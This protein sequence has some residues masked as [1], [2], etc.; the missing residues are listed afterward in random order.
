MIIL[1]VLLLSLLHSTGCT[2]Y[3]VTPDDHYY[4]NTTCHHCHCLQYYMLNTTKYFTSNTQILFLPGLHHLHTDLI[5]QS[6]HNISLIGSTTN[7]TASDTIIQ[8]NSSIGIVLTNVTNLVI[9]HITINNCTKQYSSTLKNDLLLEHSYNVQLAHVALFG[10]LQPSRNRYALRAVNVLGSSVFTDL[11]C[12]GI[13]VKYNETIVQGKHHKLLIEDYHIVPD[14]D[15]HGNTIIMVLMYQELYKVEFEVYNSKFSILDEKT[16]F[17]SQLT[18]N[19]FGNLIHINY[20]FITQ[21]TYSKVFYFKVSS[22][23]SCTAAHH[24]VKFTNSKFYDSNV[25]GL[26]HFYMRMVVLI[27]IESIIT[28]VEIKNCIFKNGRYEHLIHLYANCYG[29]NFTKIS[30]ISISNTTFS[31]MNSLNSLIDISN[32]LLLLEGPVVFTQINIVLHNAI[33]SLCQEDGNVIFHNYIEFSESN[34]DE[35]AFIAFEMCQ[36][37]QSRNQDRYIVLQENTLVNIT[38]NNYTPPLHKIR[39]SF[40]PPCYFQFISERDNLDI[41]FAIGSPL[42]Y[43]IVLNNDRSAD[44]FQHVMI[45]CYWLSGTAFTTTK[46]YDVYRKF[47]K[48]DHPL[49]THERVICSC[50][51]NSYPDCHTHVLATIYPGQTLTQQLALNQHQLRIFNSPSLIKIETEQSIVPETACNLV[52]INEVNQLL[53]NH[54]TPTQYTIIHSDFS[55]YTYWCELFIAIRNPAF[56]EK[57][58]YNIFLINFLSCPPGFAQLNGTCTCD[59]LLNSKQLSITTCDINYQAIL[60]PANAWLS[61]I[62]TNNS[63]QYRVSP[64]CPLRY[65]LPH[66]TQLNFSTLNSQCQ[67]NRSGQLCGQCQQGLSTVFGSSQCQDCS[68]S[69][70]YLFLIIPFAIAG[71]VLVLLLFTLNLTVTDGDINGFVLYVNIISINSHVFFPVNNSI[72]PSYIFISI[73]NLDLGIQTCFYNGMDDYAKMWLQLVF[74]AYLI[75]IATSLIIASRHSTRIQRVTACRALPIL[76]TLFLLSYT[77]VLHT[78]SSV[79]FYYSTIVHLPSKHTRL[80]WAV[81]ANI[82]LFGFKHTILFVVCLILFIILLLFNAILIFTKVLSRFK[83]I[84]RFKPLID[85]FQGPHK[86][87]YYYWTGVQLVMRAVFFGLSALDRNVNLSI[88]V[89]LLAITIAVHADFIPFKEKAKHYNETIFLLNLLILYTFSFGYHSVGVDI[90]IMIAAVQLV[91]IIIYHVITNVCGGMIMYTLTNIVNNVIRWINR[92]NHVPQ[93]HRELNNVPPDKAYNYLEYQE[94]LIGED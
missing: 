19:K 24:L 41:D 65:C 57:S 69:N 51:N 18:Q 79:L 72:Q 23:V 62:I 68:N 73:A 34:F 17:K 89:I 58:H 12:N 35:G 11:T 61:A 83:L 25:E 26:Y 6:V 4:P 38:N 13:I 20:C 42:N 94:P 5:I 63:Y 31:S 93:I 77:K 32:T 88:G 37:F 90:M 78:N 50:I 75:I 29:L 22:S 52:K 8:C 3:T 39:H 1:L 80:V 15:V 7:G 2:V 16:L 9:K 46:P 54:C 43:S 91:I 33:I 67:F 55:Y 85:A 56:T 66:P 48:S 70:Y 71:L 36:F 60:R 21:T 92:L 81:D 45:H 10:G 47:I 64:H 49:F 82:T 59:P 87:K 27:S 14:E 30:K 53:Y 86:Y 84:N 40:Y 74:P 76:A 44:F 28:D